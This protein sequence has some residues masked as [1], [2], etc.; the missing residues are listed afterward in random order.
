MLVVGQILVPPPVSSDASQFNTLTPVQR[1]ERL[2]QRR[3]EAELFNPPLLSIRNTHTHT[4][5]GVRGYAGSS[6]LVVVPGEVFPVVGGL[7]SHKHVPVF[8]NL[9]FG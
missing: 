1:L 5:T 9:L 4:N 7:T 8:Q 3:G 6:E 2:T